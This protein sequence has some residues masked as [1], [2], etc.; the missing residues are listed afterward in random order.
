VVGLMIGLLEG[1]TEG[2]LV[3]NMESLRIISIDPLPKRKA[4]LDNTSDRQDRIRVIELK[5]DEAR[6]LLGTPTL[7]PRLFD[8]VW[9]DGDHSYEQVKRDIVNYG[10]F[11]REG[12]MI[13]GHDYGSETY[14]GVKKAVDDLI[15]GVDA[16]ADYVWFKNV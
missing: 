6:P 8:Y 10:P 9:I 7:Y 14:Q 1:N 4:F 12:G 13:G 3:N 2:F 15:H 5:S 16:L 11:V